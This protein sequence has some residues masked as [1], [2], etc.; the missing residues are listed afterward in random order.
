M[1]ADAT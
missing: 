1:K